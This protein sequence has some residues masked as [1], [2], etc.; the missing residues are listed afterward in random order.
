MSVTDMRTLRRARTVDFV[1][2]SPPYL[3]K[4]DYTRIFAPELNLSGLDTNKDLIALRHQTIHSHVEARPALKSLRLPKSKLLEEV[5]CQISTRSSDGRHKP[6]IGGYFK[7]MFGFLRG[8]SRRLNSRGYLCLV[9]SNVQF[10]G[11]PVPVDELLAEFAPECGFDLEE[12]WVL[13]HRGNSSQQMANNGRNP[14]RESVLF[15]RKRD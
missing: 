12:Q 10:A 8:S 14:S 1:I 15:F 6:M 3:N 11:V 2:T 13:R 9:I 5:L 4:H 7:D